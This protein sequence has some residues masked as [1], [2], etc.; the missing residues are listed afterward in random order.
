MTEVVDGNAPAA[1]P[2]IADPARAAEIGAALARADRVALD[3]EFVAGKRFAAQLCLVQL[4]WQLD[5]APPQLALLDA[6]A[7]DVAA[8]LA[9][10]ADPA[11]LTVVH[12]ARQ[13]V[14]V[15]AAA[16]V[17]L[18]RLFDTQLAAALVGLGDQV[19][20]GTLLAARLGVVHDKG[21]Q[22]TDWARRPLSPAQLHYAAGDVAHLLALHGALADELAARGRAPWLAEESAAVVQAGLAAAAATDDDAWRG[23]PQRG[24]D[25]G[26]VAVL[27]ALAIWRQGAARR[28]DVPPAHVLADKLVVE[29]ARER[30]RTERALRDVRGMHGGARVHAEA[31]AEIVASALADAPDAGPAAPRW[32]PPGPRVALWTEVILALVAEAAGATGVPARL[33]TARAGAEELARLVDAHGVAV[34]PE[35]PLL[36]TWRRDVVGGAVLAWLRG[37]RGLRGAVDLPAGVRLGDGG[38]A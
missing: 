29:I 17:T 1:P 26:S 19:G 28:A 11:R 35:H 7:V 4:A 24:L 33:L 23:L 13:D 12:A 38:A 20:L 31:I 6:L 10:L 30:P 22:W 9:P 16:G 2:L 25:G 27:R 36:R 32:T 5:G 21:P 34:E 18:G 37:E 8:V 14:E 15:L 3:V